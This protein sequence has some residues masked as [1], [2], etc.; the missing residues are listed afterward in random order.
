MQTS[1]LNEQWDVIE[2]T[3]NDLIG[4]VGCL[5]AGIMDLLQG[6]AK[7]NRRGLREVRSAQ[8]LLLGIARVG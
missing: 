1:G 6:Q 8:K 3:E 5:I 7:W 2:G 4:T